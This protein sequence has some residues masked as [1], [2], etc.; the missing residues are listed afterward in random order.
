MLQRYRIW[1]SVA[2]LGWTALGSW[3]ALDFAGHV[4][5]V[6]MHR[7]NYALAAVTVLT[8]CGVA[9]CVLAA[10]ERMRAEA[11]EPVTQAFRHGWQLSREQCE[12]TCYPRPDATVLT[13]PTQREPAWQ[14]TGTTG[15]HTYVDPN[16]TTVILPRMLDAVRRRP[17]PRRPGR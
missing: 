2:A 17:S 3:I 1:L 8:M 10:V 12:K 7:F 4:G 5:K 16:A 9:G 11:V 6:P 15:R 13:F 14:Q